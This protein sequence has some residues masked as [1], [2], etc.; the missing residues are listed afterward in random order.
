M[1]VGSPEQVGVGE[2]EL[3]LSVLLP[4]IVGQ[5]RVTILLRIG[6]N[7][8]ILG[9]EKVEDDLRIQGPVPW[10]IEDEYGINFEGFGRVVVVDWTGEGP[11]G[12]IVIGREYLIEGP[13]GRICHDDV[14][15]SDDV[16]K[17]VPF[18]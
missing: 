9:E 2:K 7:N 4:S 18:R 6:A 14:A 10:I 15:G 1:V 5:G 11:M 17:A 13:D 12:L 16:L 8:P 3:G